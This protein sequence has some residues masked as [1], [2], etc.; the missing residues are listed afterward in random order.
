MS[1]TIDTNLETSSSLNGHATAKSSSRLSAQMGRANF[2]REGAPKKVNSKDP[3]QV[4]SNHLAKRKAPESLD[5]LCKA[6]GTALIWGLN[7]AQLPTA[8]FELL[9]LVAQ[10]QRK[11][12]PKPIVLTDALTQWLSGT[13][14]QPQSLEY[15]LECLAVAHLLP[16]AAAHIEGELWWS[17]LDTLAD[18]VEQ[19]NNWH[20][21][22]E[23]PPQQGL[24]HQ[25]LVGELPL[26]LAYLFPEI[27]PL[28]KLRTAGWDTLAEGLDEFLNGAGLPPASFLSVFRGL[29]ACWTRCCALTDGSKKNIWS[30]K[31]EA[32][33][34]MA[35]TRSLC[36]SSATGAALLCGEDVPKWTPDFLACLL[37]VGGDSSDRSAAR[38]LFDKKLTKQLAGKSGKHVPEF[39]EACE[40]ASLAILRTEFGRDKAVLAVDYSAPQM[41]LDFWCGT[42]QLLT[43]RWLAEPT[44]KGKKLNPIGQWEET[45][46]FSDSDID[47]IELSIE[48]ESDCRIERQI[49]LARKD[50]FLLLVDN[51]MDS[52]G[53]STSH[54][55]V[56]PLGAGIGFVPE[57]DTREG[58]LMANKPMARVLPIALPEWRIDPRIGELTSI[59]G[60]LQLVEDRPGKNLS[61]PLFFDFNSKRLN[62]AC[63]WRQLTVAQALEIQPPDVAAG[64][65]I[66]SGKDQWLVYRS[67]AA[68]ANRTVLGY[69]L[70]I[71]GVIGRFR[72]PSGE[73]EELLQVEG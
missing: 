38:D 5:R 10:I 23:V 31:A 66:Q 7:P 13:Q 54:R 8:T 4:W 15:A 25:L 1:A 67:Q 11:T 34:Q 16:L 45:C 53:E 42:Q 40:W 21:D 65:R 18:A 43:G 32:Q 58:L 71:E 49:A 72:S 69:N 64:Y 48:Y 19:S 29:L 9:Q 33:Y 62:K 39:S 2:W 68:P 59:D 55:I 12:P 3:W 22:A 46:W 57:A 63:T 37:H 28:Y 47:Y 51:V 24:A 73:V 20:I 61:C 50:K 60:Q 27:R 70:S 36:L 6:K 30:D 52:P 14:S 56:L 41:K 26:T 17:A 35:V 44:A